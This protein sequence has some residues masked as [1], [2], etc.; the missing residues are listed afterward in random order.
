MN[1]ALF[2]VSAV[3]IMCAIAY[4]RDARADLKRALAEVAAL[5]ADLERE[6]HSNV[7]KLAPRHPA[8]RGRGP[9]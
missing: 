1:A 2:L 9:A 4:V 7:V 5:R 8:V 6:R 3:V